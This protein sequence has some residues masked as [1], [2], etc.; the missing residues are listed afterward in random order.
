MKV[1]IGEKEIELKFNF[2][3]F[4]MF[5]KTYGHS[6][7][8]PGLQETIDFV[9]FTLVGS[10]NDYSLD[11]GEYR[12]WLNENPD[13]FIELSEWVGKN[14]DLNDVLSGSSKKKLQKK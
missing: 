8:A 7:N 4:T 13:K 2:E 6:L 14:M 12:K 11:Y 5:E 10:S 9:F 1:K 3:A